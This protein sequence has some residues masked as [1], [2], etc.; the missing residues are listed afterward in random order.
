MQ[1]LCR[2]LTVTDPKPGEKDG[3]KWVSQNAECIAIDEDGVM[4]QVFTI[5]L[6]THLQGE[7]APKPGIYQLVW[8]NHIDYKTREMTSRPHA[9]LAYDIRKTPGQSPAPAPA[10]VKA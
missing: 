3:R 7:S 9:F 1:N 4:G 6:P 10:A 2:V 8:A 5:R